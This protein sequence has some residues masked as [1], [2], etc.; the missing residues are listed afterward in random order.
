MAS[1]D[2][3]EVTLSSSGCGVAPEAAYSDSDFKA[4]AGL[5]RLDGG[6]G[7]GESSSGA[8]WVAEVL[9]LQILLSRRS[10]SAS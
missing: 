9:G 1:E 4:E 8:Y 5:W 6:S 3:A 2:A 7:A 10:L